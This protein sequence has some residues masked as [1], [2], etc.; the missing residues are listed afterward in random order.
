MKLSLLQLK[1]S[2]LIIA[3]GYIDRLAEVRK[4]GDFAY[5]NR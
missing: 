4:G 2:R 5:F 1:Q 3:Y